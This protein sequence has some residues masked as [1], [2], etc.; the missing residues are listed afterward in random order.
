[1]ISPELVQTIRE[2]RF[3]VEVLSKRYPSSSWWRLR[4]L[5]RR[6][7]EKGTAFEEAC[8]GKPEDVK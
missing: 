2:S 6:S 1:M 5:A 4:N 8:Q 7:V 3:A